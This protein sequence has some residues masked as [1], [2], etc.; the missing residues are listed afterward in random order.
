MNSP[1]AAE[2]ETPK[3]KKRKRAASPSGDSPVAAKKRGKKAIKSAQVEEPEKVQIKQE[4]SPQA[5]SEGSGS[6]S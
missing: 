2:A 4:A 5:R 3:T 1:A 6:P